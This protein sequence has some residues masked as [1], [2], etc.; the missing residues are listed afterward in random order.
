M[1]AAS[2]DQAFPNELSTAL[3]AWY[4]QTAIT[5]P[6]RGSRNPYRIWL[7]EIML[8]QTRITAVEPYYARFLARF[9]DVEALA[10]AS[11]DEVLNCWEGLGYYARARNLHRLAQVI[12]QEHAGQFPASAAELEKLPGIGRY[13]AAAIASIAFGE[14]V[15]VLDGNVVRVLARL[16]DLPDEV[17]QPGVQARLWH[18]AQ[19]LLSPE[20]PG[21]HNQ[22]LMDLGRLIC[23]PRR[24]RCTECPLATWCFAKARG[25]AEQ[26]P[27]KPAKAPLPHV[28]AVAAVIRDEQERVLL[29]RRP[30]EGLLG[31]L[32]MLPGGHCEPAESLPDGLR[33]TLRE[34][35]NLEIEVGGQMAVAE[36]RLT[37]FRMTMRAFDCTLAGGELQPAEA[38]AFV[39]V[40]LAEAQTYSL[41]KADREIVEALGCWQPRLFEEFA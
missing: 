20:R 30:P 36:Q 14:R 35:L 21:D 32:W 39:W 6:W 8:Q 18:L 29:Y 3:L 37:H 25:T 11:L 1:G 12:V 2:P 22:A 19:T 27:V 17:T 24:P 5:L 38:A 34:T 16:T 31:G 15:A 33:R 28:R 23:T 9:P 41:G 7:S 10:A 13:T 4:D 40:T 26:R